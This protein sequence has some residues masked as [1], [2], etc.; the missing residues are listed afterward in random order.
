GRN[1]ANPV[2]AVASAAMLLR[3][4]LS[5][6]EEAAA[7]ERA[8]EAALASGARTADLVPP[9]GPALSTTGMTETI[10]HALDGER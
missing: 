3:H 5:L 10:V 7:V 6:P 4:G 2:G 1:V 8:I 9:G